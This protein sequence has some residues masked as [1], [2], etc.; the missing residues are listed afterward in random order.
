MR[1]D[2]EDWQQAANQ[3]VVENLYGPTEL[4]IACSSYRWLPEHSPSQCRNDVVPIGRLYPSLRHVLIDRFGQPHPVEGELC[5][6]GPQM[7]AGYLDPRDDDNRFLSHDGR[8]WYRTG[9]QVRLQAGGAGEAGAAGGVLQYL[10]RVDHQVKIRGYRV[11]LAEIEHAARALPGI[12]QAVA[13]PVRHLGVVELAMFYTGSHLEPKDI[14]V[15]LAQ[16]LPDYMV[17]HWVWRLDDL[18]LNANQKVDRPALANMAAAGRP[19]SICSKS[20]LHGAVDAGV[21]V[22]LTPITDADVVPVAEFLQR[23]HDDRVPWARACSAVPWKVEAPNHGFM[24]RDGQ[25][26]V[27]VQLAFYA[28]RPVAGRTERFCNLGAWYVLPDFRFHSI[29]L[30]MAVLAQDGYHFTSLSPSGNVTSIT[31]RLKF[32]PLDT[33]AALVPNL[34]WPSLPG[35]TRISADPD[36]IAS[37]LRGAE[38]ELYRDHAQALAARHLVLIRG[39]DSC[40]VVYREMRLKGVPFAVILHVS[41]PELFHRALFP[42]TRHLLVRRR[43]LATRAELRII[44][45]RPL[46]SV[47]R[48]SW[49]K[50]Y[51]SA[52]L[53]PAQIDDLYSELVC[54][55]W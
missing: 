32:R 39:Q 48:D 12:R 28:E 2:A 15:A 51:R 36:V 37:T 35:R 1:Q 5:V 38:L 7:F 17:P 45:H 26:V 40:Y 25:R 18:P 30:L 16:S 9:D 21:T 43:L 47:M 41:N 20:R 6:T 50:L 23:N 10:G 19:P 33:S 13:V 4:T 34:P 24:L 27:G 31:A 3:S 46:L 55:P 11:E 22:E 52:S 14:T 42:L 49:P 44:G 29:R 54:V 53:E 8:R